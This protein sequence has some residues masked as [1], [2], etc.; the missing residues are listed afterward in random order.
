MDYTPGK[1]K[2]V[3]GNWIYV[4]DPS[5]PIAMLPFTIPEYEANAQLMAKSPRMF[6]LLERLL[7]T[8]FDPNGENFDTLLPF[9]DEANEIYRELNNC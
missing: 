7:N 1:W 2:V 4:D 8:S 6:E 5:N 3:Q 9:L